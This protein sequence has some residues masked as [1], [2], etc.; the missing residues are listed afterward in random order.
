[1][2]Y[3]IGSGPAGVSC[4]HALLSRGEE[5][6]LID[7]GIE[8]EKGVIKD[9]ETVR[10]T[11]PKEWKNPATSGGAIITKIK[12]Q[13]KPKNGKIDTK[14]VFGS[15]YPYQKAQQQLGVEQQGASCKPS[16]AKGGFSSVWGAAI[17]PYPRGDVEVWPITFEQLEPYYR[18]VAG[19]MEIAGCQ[20][21][22]G[23]L[24]PLYAE[25]LQKYRHSKQAD[26]F[27]QDMGQSQKA[28]N[29]RGVVFGSSRLAMRIAEK[30]GK[31]GCAYCGLCM[32]GCPYNLIYNSAFTLEELR[33][34]RLFHYVSGV[35]VEKVIENAGAVRIDGR[36]LSTGSS[37]SFSGSRVF[38]ACGAVPSTRIIL[39]SA[40][41][42]NE[43]ITLKDSQYF[44]VPLVRY[45]NVENVME[46]DLHTLAQIFVE[47]FDKKISPHPVHLQ[48]Y[49]YNELMLRVMQ[50]RFGLLYPLFRWPIKNIIGRMLLI[51][52]FLHSDHSASITMELQKDGGGT[53][54]LLIR[55]TTP[56]E[57]KKIIKKVMDKLVQE[58][59]LLKAVPLLPMV[60]MELPG[61]SFHYG[62]SMPMSK[63]PK[64]MES[65]ILGR[66]CGFKKIHV[67][68]SSVLPTLPAP[69]VTFAVM[70]NAYRIGSEYDTLP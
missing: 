11:P 14:L 8:P 53:E 5:V 50:A 63:N 35:I 36:S 54:K 62:S 3:V 59:N 57:A 4:A 1:M 7:V 26:S 58:R 48:I 29:A 34:N 21:G 19:F 25:H 10:R 44:L 37:L 28:L 68:D 56:L 40:T 45:K 46:E 31:P 32:Y 60:D 70:A 66:P 2:L 20:D 47:I 61:K 13:T 15:D 55:S 43:P 69:T 38:L 17:L 49:T 12:D 52:G 9:L 6:T 27:L 23:E 33:K 41:R 22:L 24:F 64:G 39:A 30:E 42:Y 16:F 65:D 18:K 67:V 51:Q